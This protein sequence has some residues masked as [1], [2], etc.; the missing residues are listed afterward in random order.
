MPSAPSPCIQI[1]QAAGFSADFLLVLITTLSSGMVVSHPRRKNVIVCRP[2]AAFVCIGDEIL[3]GRTRD[4]NLSYLGD[5]LNRQG[6]DLAEARV[7]ADDKA[8]IVDAVNA[9]RAHYDYVFTSG[10][11]GA[12]HDDITAAS[13]AGAFDLELIEDERALSMLFANYANR[14]GVNEARRRMARMPKGADLIRGERVGAP[15]FV[16]ENVYVM[17]GVPGIFRAMLNSLADRLSGGQVWRSHSLEAHCGETTL[18][19]DLTRVQQANQ[20][21]KIGSYPKYNAERGHYTQLVFRGPDQQ[22]IDNAVGQAMEFLHRLEVVFV[23]LG[24][25]NASGQVV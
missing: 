25:D 20:Q 11:I 17:A 7:V 10:G 19:L 3:S 23:D 12:T 5:W 4:S 8:A 2:Q 6:I 21:I 24:A 13:I 15:G 18:A 14:G 16:V 1:T 22:A 9:L